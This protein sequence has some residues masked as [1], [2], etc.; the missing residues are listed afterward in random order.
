MSNVDSSWA[1]SGRQ[2]GATDQAEVD[3]QARY[4]GEV[5][6]A[7]HRWGDVWT[8]ALDMAGD[9]DSA[10]ALALDQLGHF[11]PL[12]T[13][14]I[15]DRLLS[16]AHGPLA[17]VIELGSGFGGVLRHLGRIMRSRGERPFLVGIE[18]VPDHCKVAMTIARSLGDSTTLTVT[19]DVGRLPL[20]SMSI[21]AVFACGSA[22]HFSA[23]AKA[24]T[25]AHRVLRPGGVLAMTEEVSLRPVAGPQVGDAF[26]R[27]H[28]PG[29]FWVESPQNRRAQLKASGFTV[30]T[31]EPIK[32]WAG[33]LLRQR[34]RALGFFQECAVRVFGGAAYQRLIDTLKTA[35]YEYERGSIQPTLIVARRGTVKASS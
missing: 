20:H 29:V 35:A 15:A 9:R 4:H 25:E 24:L 18:L 5:F 23:M 16:S 32:E 19:G 11:G 28:P 10:I 7:L 31:F 2:T 1:A 6:A 27:H 17:R 3:T 14:L 22:S 34:V 26:V 21:D 13:E 8:A 30:E 12:G 33:A